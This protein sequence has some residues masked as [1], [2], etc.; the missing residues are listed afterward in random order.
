VTLYGADSDDDIGSVGKVG[1]GG[2]AVDSVE[3]MR[4]LYGGFDFTRIS[5]SLTINGPATQILAMYMNAASDWAIDKYKA[6]H[7]NEV[8][9]VDENYR[10]SVAAEAA[11]KPDQVHPEIG[12]PV[13]KVEEI[14]RDTWR[15]LRGTVQADILKEVQAQNEC[16][17]QMDFSVKLMGDVQEFFTRTGVNKFYSVSISGYHIGEAG[18][19]PAQELAYTLGNGFTYLENLVGRGLSVDEAALNLSWFF[20]NS[21]EIEWLAAGPISRK[22]W[23]IPLRDVYGGNARSQMLK[24]H[25]QTS[26]RALQVAEWDTLNPV[27]QTLHAMIALFNNT[28]SLHVDSADEPTNT[29][30]EKFVRQATMI[31]NIL[32]FEA[33]L[34]ALQNMLA[35][36]YGMRHVRQELQEQ[37]LH[38][39]ELI[40]AEGGVGPATE[41][42]FHRGRIADSSV[43]YETDIWNDTR[44]IIGRNVLPLASQEYPPAQLVRPTEADWDKQLART[45][46]FR[47][48]NK[49]VSADWLRHIEETAM[50]GDNVFEQL[51]KAV[52]YTTLGQTSK[53]LA[54]VGG[55]FSQPV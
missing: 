17:F 50:N 19:T 9:S 5:T 20:R 33:E 55:L 49:E 23:A 37:I 36:S 6:E 42:G 29:P 54:K 47:E 26:G 46:G 25:T 3:D 13:G 30:S 38:E 52:R 15:Q 34:F 45:R 48:K 10:L 53:S 51:L 12:L 11:L 8:S 28:N 44:P 22:I 31:P 39:L 35:G 24:F 27:R 41:M 4:I 21:H 43:R 40:D 18:A 14:R 32:S 16:I 2:V 7:P 1:E